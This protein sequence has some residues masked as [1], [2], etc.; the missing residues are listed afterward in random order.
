[1]L[2]YRYSTRVKIL[3]AP[4]QNSHSN[5]CHLV[6]KSVDTVVLKAICTK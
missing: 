1:M 5:I 6:K 2:L 4:Y 3:L